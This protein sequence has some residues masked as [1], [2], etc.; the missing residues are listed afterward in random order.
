M[1]LAVVGGLSWLKKAKATG[2]HSRACRSQ[3]FYVAL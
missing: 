3:M 1:C 2:T